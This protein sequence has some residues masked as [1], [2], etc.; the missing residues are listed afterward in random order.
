MTR[1]DTSDSSRRLSHG[2]PKSPFDKSDQART[3]SSMSSQLYDQ[4][5]VKTESVYSQPPLSSTNQFFDIPPPKRQR[6]SFP[7]NPRPSIDFSMQQ[8]MNTQYD[9]ATFADTHKPVLSRPCDQQYG[10]YTPSTYGLPAEQP[11]NWATPSQYTT[12]LTPQSRTDTQ[13]DTSLAHH[14]HTATHYAVQPTGARPMYLGHSAG[15]S[16]NRNS[17]GMA[18]LPSNTTASY[19]RVDDMD[20]WNDSGLHGMGGS[21]MSALDMMDPLFQ[22]QS[23]AS[24]L[25][26]YG[27]VNTPGS[28]LQENQP[29]IR[30]PH[31]SDANLLLNHG[32]GAGV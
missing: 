22:S 7:Q 2:S 19:P 14:M 27:L 26:N 18:G 21:D 11:R 29:N 10:R 25:A 32:L 12:S 20:I 1:L 16:Y 4:Q 5:A 8:G 28:F 15:M 24:P 13:I 6:T 23:L 30:L 3:I 31:D 17:N 9:L